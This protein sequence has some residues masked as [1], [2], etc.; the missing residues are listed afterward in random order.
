M[1][2]LSLFEAATMSSS[3]IAERSQQPG[4][5]SF[6]LARPPNE[7]DAYDRFHRG[8]GPILIEFSTGKAC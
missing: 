7:R 6:G 5:A 4:L 2:P 8:A 1:E 3:G